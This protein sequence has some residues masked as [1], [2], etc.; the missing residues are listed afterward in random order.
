LEPLIQ[1]L[2]DEG[3]L[4]RFRLA[5]LARRLREIEAKAADLPEP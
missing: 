1:R 3:T 2:S 5:R 4:K